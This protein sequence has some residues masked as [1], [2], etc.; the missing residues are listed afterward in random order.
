MLAEWGNFKFN[1]SAWKKELP[2]E[3]M[4]C[5]PDETPMEWALKRFLILKSSM[6]HLFPHLIKVG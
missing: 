6:I 1:L 2:K 5:K 3:I 4:N